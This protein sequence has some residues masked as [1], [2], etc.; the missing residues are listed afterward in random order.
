MA[1]TRSA[2]AAATRHRRVKLSILHRFI[3]QL[4]YCLWDRLSLPGR[5]LQQH[6]KHILLAVD[7]EIAATGAVPFQFA[8]RT[9]RRRLGGAGVGANREAE[10]ETEAIPGKIKVVAP[11]A[12]TRTHM[13]RSHQFER[14]GA[15]I[16]L[17]LELAAIEQHLRKARE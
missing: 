17:A 8:Q 9:R 4:L 6:K 13:I 12:G 7:H 3:D 2:S 11:D 5:L 16:G 14:L 15:Q 1:T 10:P